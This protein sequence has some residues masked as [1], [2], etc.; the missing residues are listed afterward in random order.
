[1][2]L[3]WRGNKETPNTLCSSSPSNT[4]FIRSS[5]RSYNFDEAWPFQAYVYVPFKRPFI[6]DIERTFY[7]CCYHLSLYGMYFFS[8]FLSVL[9]QFSLCPL[10]YRTKYTRRQQARECASVNVICH[11]TIASTYRFDTMTFFFPLS[12]WRFLKRNK[13]WFPRWIL[14]L[15]VLFMLLFLASVYYLHG[16]GIFACCTC[17]RLCLCV[18]ACVWNIQ[19]KTTR[20]VGGEQS[21]PLACE[22]S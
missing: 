17:T 6:V 19:T 15:V 12:L 1:M 3:I 10:N 20:E 9:H 16:R 4:L 7:D 11:S 13:F 8:C 2:E 22:T 14:L 5:V 21:F 18:H